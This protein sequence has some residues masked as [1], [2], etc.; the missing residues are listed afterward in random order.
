MWG[1][2][3]LD[4]RYFLLTCVLHLRGHHANIVH[5][6]FA[7]PEPYFFGRELG[8]AWSIETISQA[9]DYVLENGSELEA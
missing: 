5:G 2:L 3:P 7:Q 1:T 4:L 8:N 6:D 9:T